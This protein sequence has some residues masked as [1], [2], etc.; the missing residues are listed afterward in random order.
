MGQSVSTQIMFHATGFIVQ[1]QHKKKSF[2]LYLCPRGLPVGWK[3]RYSQRSLS[4]NPSLAL[5]P[6]DHRTWNS[7]LNLWIMLRVLE[8]GGGLCSGRIFYLLYN[9]PSFHPVLD[10][11]TSKLITLYDF[12]SSLDNEE[13]DCGGFKVLLWLLEESMHLKCLLH[14]RHLISTGSFP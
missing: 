13:D 6:E 4:L 1:R 9:S 2:F 12:L 3:D 8:G 7:A 11:F 5:F 14:G 10:L